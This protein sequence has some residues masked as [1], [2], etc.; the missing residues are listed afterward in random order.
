MSYN[1]KIVNALNMTAYTGGFTN[2][3][4]TSEEPYSWTM[5]FQND[6]S[7]GR[8]K[9]FED[10][11]KLYAYIYLAEVGNLN[12]VIYEYKVDGETKTLSVTS[13]EA[14]EYAG[15]DIKSVGTDI[16]RL[17]MLVRKTGLS[18]VVLGGASVESDGQVDFSHSDQTEK[19]LGFTVINYA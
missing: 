15:E 19:V 1:E 17:E 2:E 18:N 4:Q 8:Q 6:F 10:R 3:L 13:S 11:L 14:S 5:I 7:S 12:E 9:A 16:N